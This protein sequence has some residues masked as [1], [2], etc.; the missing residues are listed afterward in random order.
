M[1]LKTFTTFEQLKEKKNKT[2]KWLN[3]SWRQFVFILV[4]CSLVQFNLLLGSVKGVPLLELTVTIFEL[5]LPWSNDVG[6]V[7]NSHEGYTKL[8]WAKWSTKWGRKVAD[9]VDSSPRPLNASPR[10]PRVHLH[11]WSRRRRREMEFVTFLYLLPGS[12]CRRSQN[13]EV[14]YGTTFESNEESCW[15]RG[16]DVKDDP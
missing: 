10:I 5:L 6:K 13:D 4:P 7:S 11:E 15:K 14:I 1:T 12:K 2:V 8:Y 9:R 16:I 3:K